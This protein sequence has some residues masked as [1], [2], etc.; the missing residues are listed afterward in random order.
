MKRAIVIIGGF[1][2]S[3]GHYNKM[4]EQLRIRSGLPVNIVPIGM[5]EW[6]VVVRQSGWRRLLG[7]LEQT[8]SATISE[9]ECDKIIIVAHSLGGIVT[10][11]YLTGNASIGFAPRYSDRIES[12]ITLGSPHKRG[13]VHRL[14][15][16][17]GLDD[18]LERDHL[19]VPLLSVV[20]KVD[21]SSRGRS[22]KRLAHLRYRLHGG[23]PGEFGDGIIPI[24]SAIYDADR[25][26]ILDDVSHDFRIGRPWYGDP[27]IVDMWWK[28][29]K[30][31]PSSS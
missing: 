14:S 13:L 19:S 31:N 20:G 23:D 6:S 21:Y 22:L 3:P 8:I 11:L 9:T 1:S 4:A 15:V 25:S 27:Q 30:E 12:V 7:K 26:L 5:S 28:S 18:C 2:T 17:K 24:D 16:W 10:R 29:A